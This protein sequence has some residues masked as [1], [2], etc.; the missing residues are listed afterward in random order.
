MAE[1]SEWCVQLTAGTRG[2]RVRAWRG[3]VVEGGLRRGCRELLGRAR[4][5]EELAAACESLAGSWDRSPIIESVGDAEEVGRLVEAAARLVAA[6]A[7]VSAARQQP[8]GS[9]ALLPWALR[10]AG[11]GPGPAGCGGTVPPSSTPS[12]SPSPFQSTVAPP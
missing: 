7:L 1:L 5:L 9:D 4:P 2:Q 10:A 11:L 6:A 8:G 3:L 12:L